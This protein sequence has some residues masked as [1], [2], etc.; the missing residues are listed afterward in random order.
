[1][2]DDRVGQRIVLALDELPVPP[3]TPLRLEHRRRISG[4]ALFSAA[5]AVAVAV[6][7]FATQIVLPVGQALFGG[8]HVRADEFR[9]D[10]SG[11]TI[12]RG[13]WEYFAVG[14]G[15]TIETVNGWVEVTIP[16]ATQA[17]PG[18]TISDGHLVTRCEAHGDFDVRIDYALLEWPANNG[19]YVQFGAKPPLQDAIF[20]TSPQE[21]YEAMVG[22]TRGTGTF[23]T[24]DTTGT[25]RL[26]RAASTV[27]A[28]VMS[29]GTWVQLASGPSTTTDVA[30]QINVNAEA[31][32]FQHTAVRV[33]LDNFSLTAER[34]ICPSR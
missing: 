25:F 31:G 27:T 21:A 22:G 18:R 11:T 3:A 34:V 13:R 30:F 26:T 5:V 24:S 32:R 28:Y 14:V 16:A 23:H 1:M 9:D 4:L 29:G 15:P 7:L 19:V 6:F 33:A 17:D 12:D 2:D 8:G 20:R 10:F